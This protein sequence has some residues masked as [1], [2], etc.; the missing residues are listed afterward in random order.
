MLL[1]SWIPLFQK[2]FVW[3]MT[4]LSNSP[5][6]LQK[7][8]RS[9]NQERSL[10]AS[11]VLRYLAEVAMDWA[12]NW[13][14]SRRSNGG[15]SS[16][17]RSVPKSWLIQKVLFTFGEPRL[18][19]LTLWWLE[20]SSLRILMPSRAALAERVLVF[21]CPFNALANRDLYVLESNFHD[22]WMIERTII[23]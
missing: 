4:D 21:S 18:I 3:V 19:I 8:L 9:F 13:S 10:I 14:L 11:C 20:D 23:W 7:R 1:S 12:I 16:W 15:T 17:I 5:N 2:A 6:P 22:H